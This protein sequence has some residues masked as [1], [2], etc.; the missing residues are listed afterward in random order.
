LPEPD[1]VA[2]L[3]GD[4]LAR[5]VTRTIIIMASQVAGPSVVWSQLAELQGNKNSPSNARTVTFVREI[6]GRTLTPPGVASE[7]FTD[8][9]PTDRQILADAEAAGATILVTSDV[10]DYAEADLDSVG[11]TAANPDLF[12]SIILTEDTYL[13]VL[14][15]IAAGRRNPPQTAATLH[16]QL[17]RQHPR[18]VDRFASLFSAEPSAPTHAEPRILSR[19]H[20][21]LRCGT[22]VAAKGTL[23]F[24]LCDICAATQS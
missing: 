2:F 7:R 3:D 6:L 10:D 23:A 1:V 15:Q 20:R 12:L 4:V 19:G 18:T 21:C 24:G 11:I 13:D 14:E 16:G 17:G 22:F 8:T 9:S 5:P